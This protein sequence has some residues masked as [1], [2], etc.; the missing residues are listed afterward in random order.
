VLLA[1]LVQVPPTAAELATAV[2]SLQGELAVPAAAGG[3]TVVA[4]DGAVLPWRLQALLLGG[5]RGVDAKALSAV[6]AAAVH[7]VLAEALGGPLWWGTL[8][9]RQQD[10]VGW[11]RR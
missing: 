6:D 4:L 3:A 1:D 11:P 10:G 2:R 9:P 8:L 5:L 7:A